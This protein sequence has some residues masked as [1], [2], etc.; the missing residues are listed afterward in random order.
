MIVYLGDDKEPGLNAYYEGYIPKPGW[1]FLLSEML[2]PYGPFDSEAE[3]AQGFKDYIAEKMKNIF[4]R[5]SQGCN[6]DCAF[7]CG[8]TMTTLVGHTTSYDKNG[9]LIGQ[10]NPNTITANYHCTKCGARFVHAFNEAWGTDELTKIA[11]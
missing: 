4:Q 8:R 5:M 9:N 10:G 1:Y 6:N 7:E 2:P 3:A 11:L